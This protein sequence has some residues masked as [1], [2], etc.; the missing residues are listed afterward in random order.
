VNVDALVWNIGFSLRSVVARL[1]NHERV[2]LSTRRT[3]DSTV[4][5]TVSTRTPP[6]T[7]AARLLSFG[8]FAIRSLAAGLV[9]LL[10]VSEYVHAFSTGLGK[11]SMQTA[12]ETTPGTIVTYLTT[13]LPWYYRA[14]ILSGVTWLIFTKSYTEESL[15]VV[16][17]LGLQITTS[18]PSY[19]WSSSSR[20][21]PASSIQDIFIHEAF[22]GFEVKYYLN[23]VIEGEEEIVV[24]FPVSNT[25][26]YDFIRSSYVAKAHDCQ[27]I[28]PRRQVLEEVW[29][30][31]RACLYASK[32]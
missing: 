3:T 32:P 29:R 23:I 14:I 24:V 11:T 25:S 12:L 1:D 13:H 2:M 17:E 26:E 15:L 31:A 27:N 6:T 9:V 4:L 19:L 7:L 16:R 8:T 5:Y 30:G 22:K 28:L 10:L 20:F 18:S 21:I